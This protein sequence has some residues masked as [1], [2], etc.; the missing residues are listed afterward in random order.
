MVPPRS[1]A[2]STKRLL[3]RHGGDH[4]LGARPGRTR[5]SAAFVEA[6]HVA[7]EL[8]HHALQ[9][10][11]QAERRDLVGA[12]V[13]QRAELA[14]DAAD[15][16][17][18]GHA[19]RVDVAE[20]PWP[21]RSGSRSRRR[22]PSAGCTLASWAKPAGAQRLGDREV[23]VGQV[24]V[25]A[26]QRDGD[27][28]VGVVHP[29]QQVVPDGPVDVAERQVEPA[30]DV[31]VEA[32]AVQHLRDVVDRRRVGG[33]D[34]GLLV[35]VAHQR[36]LALDRCPGSRGRRGRRSRRAGYRWSAARPPSAGSAWS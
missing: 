28:L 14:L 26:D 6:G 7:G 2:P 35:D 23:G 25:L 3:L 9:A 27:L 31:G 8:D 20:V 5:S 19:D 15:A 29:A 10:Q 22:R 1:P 11:A 34:H 32:L 30:Y 18:A 13:V 21:R 33:G 24:D 36:D 16:E 4:R 17:A 12:G